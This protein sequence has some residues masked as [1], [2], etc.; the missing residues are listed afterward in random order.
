MCGIAGIVRFS[1][2]PVDPAALQRACMAQRHRGP[3]HAGS[4]IDVRN[5][6]AVGFAAVRLAVLDPSS[7]C[8]QPFV[9]PTGRFVITYNGEIYNYRELRHELSAAGFAFRTHGDTEV[10]LAACIHWG[11]QAL[12]R[13]QGMWAFA[14]YDAR[15]R[16]G[17]IARDRFGKK[18]LLY[19]SNSQQFLFA[20]EM[21]GLSAME[22]VSGDVDPSALVQL[23]RYGYIAA[24][25]T[26][27]A[28]VL[29]LEPGHYLPFTATTDAPPIRYYRPGAASSSSTSSNAGTVGNSCRKIRRVLEQAVVA[30][31][32]SDVPI[33][34]FLSGGLDSSIVTHHLRQALGGP[35]DTFSLGYADHKSYDESSFAQLAAQHIGTRHHPLMLTSRDIIE[36][37]PTILNHLSQPVG[38]SSIIPTALISKHAR[39]WVTVALSGDGGDELFGG[40]WKYL[41][42]RSWET[43][44]RLP[45]FL[46]KGVLEPLL[47]RCASARS[48]AISNRVRQFRK[49]VRVE[50]DSA[51]TRHLAWS[52]ILAPEAETIFHDADLGL[53]LDR[54]MLADAE[55]LTDQLADQSPLARILALDVQYA[56]PADMLHKVDTASMMHS[57]EVR[58]P[59]LDPLVVEAALALP[60]TARIDR[61]I[62]KRIL[63]DAYRGILPDEVLDRPKQGFEVPMGEL[64][65]GPLG[66]MFQ[67]VVNA[68]VVDSFG[69]LSFRG[70]TDVFQQHRQRRTDH[71]DLLFA[72]L[73]LCWWR[74]KWCGME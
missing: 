40:Y 55:A 21:A 69:I 39:Q 50:S 60:I 71:A 7:N 13:L 74:G 66:D 65:R 12:T 36:S 35:I 4:W 58:V 48:S 9:D 72:L 20:S 24:P 51:L 6:G 54:E 18:P 64:F 41:G 5:H 22:P 47:A 31:R 53:I 38:D 19:I 37:V 49:L 10:L 67:D 16:S 59:F 63:I 56:L 44:H 43:Y 29:Q 14:F 25:R 8:N 62:R 27:H 61:G 46:R 15:E 23:L 26:I 34:S 52:R 73:S 42:H 68:R 45:A 17:F 28:A 11:P 30:R 3:D 33:G 2:S 32:V 70:I 1:G 57:L